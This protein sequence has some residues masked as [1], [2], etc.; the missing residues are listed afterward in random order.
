MVWRLIYPRASIFNVIFYLKRYA[1]CTFHKNLI[2]V[3]LIGFGFSME[4]I[5]P[6]I[7]FFPNRIW[8]YS[9]FNNSNQRIV[10]KHWLGKPADKIFPLKMY[11]LQSNMAKCSSVNERVYLAKKNIV[12]LTWLTFCSLEKYLDVFIFF[13]FRI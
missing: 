5:K 7:S 1:T 2:F 9:V 12:Y 4:Q 6:I 11:F 10:A 13:A 3:N 8:I